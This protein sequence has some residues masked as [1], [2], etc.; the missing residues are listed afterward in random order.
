MGA[1]N[2]AG[3]GSDAGPGARAG[4]PP[5]VLLLAPSRGL[6]GGIERYLG[7]VEERLRTG[8]ADVQRLD[9]R[10]PGTLPGVGA[11]LR[12]TA[13]AMRAAR[14]TAPLD[15]VLAGHP[16]LIPVA[17]AAATLGQAR[18]AP[19]MF[20]GT[21]IWVRRPLGRALVT[22]HRAL[23][24]LTIS[25]FSA[26]A[27]A[28]LGVTP[29]LRPGIPPAWR[30]TLLAAGARA[31]RTVRQPG[32]PTLL[33]VFR[34][35]DV[36]WA[37]KGLPALLAAL[38]AVRREVGPVRLVV[39]GRGPAPEAMR[40]AVAAAG[41]VELVES[42]DD[43]ELAW[44][45]ATADLFVLCTRTRPGRSGE[46]YGIVLTEAQLAGCPVV[47]PVSG[48]ARDAYVDGVTGATPG[49]ESPAA[50]AAV[51]TD[52]LTDRA[53]LARM[54]RR[55]AEWARMATEPAEHARA[56]FTAILGAPPPAPLTEPA[57]APATGPQQ[58]HLPQQQPLWPQPPARPAT[59]A[60]AREPGGWGGADPAAARVPAPASATDAA[61]PVPRPAVPVAR[62]ARLD[63][64]AGAGPARARRPPARPPRNR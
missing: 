62:A 10:S 30:A 15:A 6:G 24:P 25:S 9:L 61:G 47:G 33:S 50:L 34:L 55:A 21:D 13:A 16:N 52:L 49:D 28:E 11:R 3:T 37:G 51:L 39:A 19:V 48:G 1:E 58:P 2:E 53:R 5:R 36:D 44:L 64:R 8:G 42:P 57:A 20:Y 59:Q 14:R 17:A 18:R 12:F 32:P 41:D 35:S 56:V 43:N 38:P 22:R 31:A 60:T 7:F 46:G 40:R 63:P 4:Y 26:G 23:Y 45:Y 27:L 54:R 29:V